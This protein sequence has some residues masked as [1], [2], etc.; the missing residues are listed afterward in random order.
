MQI[1][2]F[3][4]NIE[5]KREKEFISSYLEEKKGRFEKL[6]RDVD[7]EIARLEAKAES[8][9]TKSAYKVELALHL[10]R[11]KYMSSED[12]H[13]LREAIDLAVDKMII[14][15]RKDRNKK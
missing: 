2:I 11:K 10:P 1:D 9:A 15:L 5:N 4:K 8:F 6:I 12:D 14:Q 13:T 7:Y 3:Y